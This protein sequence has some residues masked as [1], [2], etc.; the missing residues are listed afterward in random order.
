MAAALLP[1]PEALQGRRGAHQASQGTPRGTH[2]AL[3]GRTIARNSQSCAL[4]SRERNLCRIISGK[5]LNRKG[6]GG[7]HMLCCVLNPATNGIMFPKGLSKR[8]KREENHPSSK[9]FHYRYQL[10]FLSV[11]SASIY[12]GMYQDKNSPVVGTL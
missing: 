8:A 2:Q 9:S 10:F 12:E 3:R 7:V 6:Q 11:Y 4:C 5:I 1:K